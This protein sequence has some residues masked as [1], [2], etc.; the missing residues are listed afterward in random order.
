M[1]YRVQ[2]VGAGAGKWLWRVSTGTGRA[3]RIIGHYETQAEAQAV[4]DAMEAADG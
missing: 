1:K 3:H 2:K 4:A